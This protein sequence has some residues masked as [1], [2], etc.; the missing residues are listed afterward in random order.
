VFR[1]SLVG[2]VLFGGIA[3]VA[4]LIVYD[5][6]RDRRTKNGIEEGLKNEL[7][8]LRLFSN[9]AGTL[10]YW[11]PSSNPTPKQSGILPQSAS[12]IIWSKAPL[13]RAIFDAGGS[14]ADK[15][16]LCDVARVSP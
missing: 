11:R 12:G 15:I 13:A 6:I 7:S 16:P 10:D 8:E 14:R 5:T 4:Q 1:L 9:G 2:A 3:A